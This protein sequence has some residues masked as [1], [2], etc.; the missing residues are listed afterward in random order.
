MSGAATIR[1]QIANSSM[2]TCSQPSKRQARCVSISCLALLALLLIEFCSGCVVVPIPQPGRHVKTEYK[3]KAAALQASAASREEVIRQLGPPSLDFP[4]LAVLGY[5]WTASEWKVYW[6]YVIA[7]G[8]SATGDAGCAESTINR[9]L[10]LRF[11]DQNRLAH[12]KLTI[13]S[14]KETQDPWKVARRWSE[15]V[16]PLPTPSCG[17]NLSATRYSDGQ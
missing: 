13:L 14:D 9:V 8:Y 11:T 5:R 15:S 7:G 17:T 10:W 16:N 4:D 12:W 3:Q 1:E 2:K 6:A